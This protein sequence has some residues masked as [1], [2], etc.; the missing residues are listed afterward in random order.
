MFRTISIVGLLLVCSIIGT[1]IADDNTRYV[2]YLQ[3]GAGALSEGANGTMVLT[4]ADMVPYYSV[5]VMNRN[6][7][8]PLSQDTLPELP[9]D[10]A[11]VQNGAE[12]E[13]VYLIKISSWNYAPDTNELSLAIAPVEF[14]E[15]GLL[16]EF[17]DIKG[18]L[19][20][21]NVEEAL[22]IGLYLESLEFTPENAPAACDPNF[23]RPP[24]VK[25]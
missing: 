10:A 12:G 7:L 23:W 11:L 20:A 19:S 9:I 14:Y 1:G 6:I 25:C 15:G 3:G 22:S 2:A 8:M 4:I 21:E 13:T 17:A 16:Q 18:E 5:P 24:G